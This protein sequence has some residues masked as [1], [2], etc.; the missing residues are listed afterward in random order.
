MGHLSVKPLGRISSP[1]S[2]VGQSRRPRALLRYDSIPS[3]AAGT[4]KEPQTEGRGEE[5]RKQQQKSLFVR[6]FDGRH[7]GFPRRCRPTFETC[8]CLWALAHTPYASQLTHS[9]GRGERRTFIYL[10][11]KS[12]QRSITQCH[13]PSARP[14]SCTVLLVVGQHTLCDGFFLF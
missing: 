9:Q 6:R 12:S 5:G 3:E 7:W 4:S 2:Q 8:C 10:G 1:V 13:V 14:L 11:S